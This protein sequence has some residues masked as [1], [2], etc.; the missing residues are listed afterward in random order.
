[1]STDTETEQKTVQDGPPP[2]PPVAAVLVDR[3]RRTT[4]FQ[5]VESRLEDDD[6]T[7]KPIWL[8]G[9]AP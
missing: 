1:M 4:A 9:L 8:R 5:R 7:R 6:S 3:F 2:R